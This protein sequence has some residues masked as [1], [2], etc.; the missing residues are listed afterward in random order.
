MLTLPVE[1]VLAPYNP[2]ISLYNPDCMNII[3]ASTF[4]FPPN[5]TPTYNPRCYGRNSGNLWIFFAMSGGEIEVLGRG[6]LIASQV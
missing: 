5:I 6:V 2:Y 1:G 3:V 4:S